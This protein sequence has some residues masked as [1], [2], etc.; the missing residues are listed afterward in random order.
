MKNKSDSRPKTVP[1]PRP[2]G[3]SLREWQTTLRRQAA[4]RGSFAVAEVSDRWSPGLY[5]VT[6]MQSRRTYKVNYHGADSEWNYCDCMDYRTSCLGTCKHIEA[7]ALWLE[8]RNKKPVTA[9]PR[10]PALYISYRGGRKLRLRL[11]QDT[12]EELTMAAM[13]YFDD[14]MV[15]VPG[16]VAELPSFM[17]R[18]RKID[19]RFHCYPDALNY[20]IEERDRRRRK[21]RLEEVTETDLSRLLHT[22][23]YPYQEEGI[24]FAFGAGRS[25]IA[26]EMGLGKT[27]QAIGAAELM[28]SKNMIGSVLIVCPTSLKYQWKK[29]IE[30]F[31]DSDVTMIEGASQQRRKLYHEASFY[32][33]VSY[34][35][36]ANDIKS[37]GTLRVDCMIMDEV[38]RLKN[39]NTQISQAARRVEADYCVV[40]SGTPLE[41]KPEELYSVMQFVDQY[42]LGPYYEFIDRHVLTSPSG[43]VT[44]YTKLDNIS[45]RLKNCLIRRRKTDVMLQLPERT[46]KVLFVPM[47]REQREIHDQYQ[48][49][50]AQLVHKW[51]TMRFLSE[52][53]RKRLLLTLSQ[54]RMVCDS[55]FVLDQK[56]RFDTKIGEALQ[57]VL[58]M[59]ECGD[60]KAVIFSQWE[61][62]TRILAEELDRAGVKYEYLHGGVPSAKRRKLTENFDADAETRV[63]LSTDAGST[64]LNLQAASLIINLDMPWNPAV[65]EQRI[66]R[67]HRLGQTKRIQVVNMVSAGTIEERMLAKLNFKG[68]LLAGVLDGGESQITLDDSKLDNIAKIF[69]EQGEAVSDE[70]EGTL[71]SRNEE[72]DTVLPAA[73]APNLTFDETE[74]DDNVADT[75]QPDTDTARLVANGVNFISS[76]ARTLASPEACSRLIDT[77]VTTDETTGRTELRIPVES[78]ESVASFLSDLTKLFNR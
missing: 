18:A 40:L 65:L 19:P 52:K 49:S 66:A 31:T 26:D 50:V 54:M 7:V 74:P 4:E 71:V 13:R 20:I 39:W 62:M 1:P 35:T 21:A 77:L 33:I 45:A 23:L 14:D 63:F 28:K 8:K 9:L 12:P 25:L 38:Q 43:K 58:A 51:Q 11:G 3:M 15:A 29:E 69:A 78:K 17:E 61:R 44:G 48:T 10:R 16:M 53:D 67:I 72:S 76:L 60:E 27:V 70:S 22:K 46:D 37:L 34:H 32:R 24:R 47:T 59:I 6:G 68:N 36:L 57:L 55:T 56:T 30:R 2:E 73:T 64:G 75:E 41:N 5:S 42:A